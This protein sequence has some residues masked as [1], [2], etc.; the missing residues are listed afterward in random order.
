MVRTNFFESSRPRIFAH[1]GSWQHRQDISENSLE[2]FLEALSKG[3]SHIESDVQATLDGH[4][5]LFHD[6]DL[7]RV[8]NSRAIV[9]EL[10]LL[11]LQSLQLFGGGRVPTLSQVLVEIP[12]AKLNLDIK[13]TLAISAT[14]AA[15]EKH[16]AHDRIL[17]TSFSNPRRKSVLA[18]LSIPVATSAASLTVFWLWISHFL[19]F[20]FGLK[21]ILKNLDA[22]Q[23]PVRKGLLRFDS[24]KFISKVSSHGV[25]VHFWTINEPELMRKLIALGAHGIVTDR[26]DLVPTEFLHSS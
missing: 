19:L 10:T 17:I 2:S 25:E 16:L 24:P 3:A 13:S 9:S 6:K 20:G 12:H 15:I 23:V 5:V 14:A 26:V 18:G 11:E 21:H 4:A 8:S 22:I 1:R 7:S